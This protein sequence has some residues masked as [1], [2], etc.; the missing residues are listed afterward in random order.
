MPCTAHTSRLAPAVSAA[1]P[2]LIVA[3][4]RLQRFRRSGLTAGAVK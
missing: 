1:H 2:P 4:L 3:F